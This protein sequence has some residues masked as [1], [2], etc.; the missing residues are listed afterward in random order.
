MFIK[1]LTEPLRGV[2]GATEVTFSAG[3][4]LFNKSACLA[5]G[6][7]TTRDALHLCTAE[8]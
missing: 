2:W 3:L 7:D 5:C 6:R 1:V 4:T 8:A